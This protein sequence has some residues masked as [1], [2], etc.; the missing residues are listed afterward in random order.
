MFKPVNYTCAL[1]EAA[2]RRIWTQMFHFCYMFYVYNMYAGDTGSKALRNT[3]SGTT[4]TMIT[5]TNEVRIEMR[6]WWLN[7]ASH[8]KASDTAKILMGFS[9]IFNAPIVNETKVG[10]YLCSEC[11]RQ[12]HGTSVNVKACLWNSTVG[13]E[14]LTQTTIVLKSEEGHINLCSAHAPASPSGSSLALQFAPGIKAQSFQRSCP[15]VLC[16]QEHLVW[17]PAKFN[18]PI[19]MKSWA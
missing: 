19:S 7:Y 15:N 16:A 12:Q 3:G 9:F 10:S 14:G 11:G 18:S 6:L 13:L 1:S 8:S 5:V 2:P 4:P 17:T